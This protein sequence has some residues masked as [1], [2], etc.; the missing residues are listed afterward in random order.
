MKALSMFIL[1]LFGWKIEGDFSPQVKKCVV[2]AAPHTSNWDFV[3][4]RAALYVLG[5]NV[6]YL[7]KKSFFVFPLNLFFKFTGG[8]AVDRSKHNNLV[9]ALANLFNHYDD[10]KIMITP[11][12]TRSRVEKWKTGFYHVAQKAKVPV[13]LGFLDYKNKIAGVGPT[14][15][16]TGDFNKDMEYIQAFYQNKNAKFPEKFNKQIFV[17]KENTGNLPN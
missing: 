14:Y 13:V 2:V 4:G 3:L 1:K 15:Y 6:K 12:G 16:L 9:D 7:I 10:L 11:E 17:A 8:I 5:I